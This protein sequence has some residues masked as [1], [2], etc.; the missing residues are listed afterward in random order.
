[1]NFELRIDAAKVYYP[2]TLFML[3]KEIYN[4]NLADILEMDVHLTKDSHFSSNS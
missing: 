3:C 1:M 2:K 4:N